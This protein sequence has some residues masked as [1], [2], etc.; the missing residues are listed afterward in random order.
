MSDEGMKF[1][2][3]GVIGSGTMGSGIA[4][5]IALSERNVVLFDISAEIVHRAMER[6]S[7]TMH[8][9]K[10]RG[11]ISTEQMQQAFERITPCWT[12][13]DVAKA[14]CIIEAAPESLELKK[15]IFQNLDTV[16]DRN[17]VFA[18]N[19]SS[20]S[21]TAIAMTVS[22][23]ERVLG[24]HFFNPAHIMKLVEV[25][26]AKWTN[27]TIVSDVM[28]FAKSLGKTPV[29]VSDTPGFIVNRVAR[30]FYNE[31]LRILEERITEPE[32]IDR[33]MTAHGFKMGPFTLMDLIG[34]DVNYEVT[35]SL[36]DA[37]H[38]DPRYRPSFIQRAMVE[39]GLLG[40]KSGQG[41]YSHREP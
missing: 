10:E 13:E 4:I 25:V 9:S 30:P 5:T 22:H 34:N 39:A 40:K 15:N 24:M 12:Y 31:A 16:C 18:S 32:V 7:G 6:I 28:T 21:I 36:Y 14:E 33:I 23:P 26:Q 1:T 3:T 11:R 20:L 17:T 35:K 29:R 27:T 19:T 37:Y 2:N 41:F 8:A 38:Q